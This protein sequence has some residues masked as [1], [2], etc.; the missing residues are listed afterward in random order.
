MD[1]RLRK[2]APKI[3]LAA[4]VSVIALLTFV[5]ALT[6]GVFGLGGRAADARTELHLTT[7]RVGVVE[8]K[9]DENI[10]PKI[11]SLETQASRSTANQEM[12]MKQMD[13]IENKLE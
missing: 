5:L 2:H 10:V 1:N 4:L 11:H 3:G 9:I 6:K 13:R 12:M 7:K 8:R